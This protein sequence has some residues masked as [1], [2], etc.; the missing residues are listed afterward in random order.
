MMRTFDAPTRESCQVRRERTNTPLQ[1]LALLNETAAVEASRHL[2]LRMMQEG[3]NSCAD[4]VVHG[5]RLATGRLPDATEQEVLEHL[6]RQHLEVYRAD[7]DAAMKLLRVGETRL[8]DAKATPELAAY[9]MVANTLLNLS[10]TI[11]LN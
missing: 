6:C 3:G 10:E 7:P 5:F 9:T 11:T 8:E 2:A 1:A 4:R